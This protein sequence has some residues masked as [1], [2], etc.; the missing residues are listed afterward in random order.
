MLT[1]VIQV[2]T[3]YGVTW[4]QW[5]KLICSV[6]LFSNF[7]I[8]KA[9]ATYCAALTHVKCECNSKDIH[10]QIKNIAKGEINKQQFSNSH[11]WTAHW[12][13]IQPL[14][15]WVIFFSKLMTSF[16]NAIPFKCIIL[17]WNWSNTMNILWAL[18]ILMVW[19]FSTGASV[20]TIL[21][22]QDAFPAVYGLNGQSLVLKRMRWQAHF[23]YRLQT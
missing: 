8:I 18:W 16:S 10:L 6:L 21:R 2:V 13:P 14:D 9:L 7:E 4:P 23:F 15:N 3:P 22:M 17:L 1:S 20:A 19:C 5:V 12:L 11:L